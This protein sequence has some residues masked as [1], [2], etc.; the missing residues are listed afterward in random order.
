ME[1]ANIKDTALK[2]LT[3][4][5]RV[6]AVIATCDDGTPHAA[7][8]YYAITSD[9]K[10][11]FLTATDTKKYTHILKNNQVAFAT[12]FGPSYITIQGSGKATLLEKMSEKENH[13][14]ALIKDRLAEAG[15]TWPIFQMSDF[16]DNAIAVYELEF[17]ELNMLNLEVD[18]GLI[19][20]PEHIEKII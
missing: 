1:T 7:T 10:V 5:E 17:D 12:G 13:A 9:F 8:I 6:T 16:D 4:P 11:Y 18:N 20:T 14:V 15:T 2:F 19:T 3:D